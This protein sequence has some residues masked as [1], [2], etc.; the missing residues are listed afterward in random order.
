MFRRLSVSSSQATKD[1]TPPP[2]PPPPPP[3]QGVSLTASR[4]LRKRE[5]FPTFGIGNVGNAAGH[6]AN[7]VRGGTPGGNGT[8]PKLKRTNQ[9]HKL[10]RDFLS[11]AG[12]TSCPGKGRR[13][14]WD[15]VRSYSVFFLSLFFLPVSCCGT[16]FLIRYVNPSPVSMATV[17]L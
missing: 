1:W 17:I 12:S 15:S 2:P 7:T 9:E 16:T 14:R 10:R 8:P 3:H 4:R 13:E 5:G 11:Q 6:A